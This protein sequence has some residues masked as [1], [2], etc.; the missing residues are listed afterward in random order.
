M[1]ALERLKAH[2]SLIVDGGCEFKFARGRQNFPA[3]DQN[4]D[5]SPNQGNAN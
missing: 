1:L 2:R 5:D 3:L 4:P